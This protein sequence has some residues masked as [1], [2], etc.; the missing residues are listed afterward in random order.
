[1]SGD[2]GELPVY[3]LNST[4]I[5]Y[6]AVNVNILYEGNYTFE[7]VE[8]VGG[9]DEI[10]FSL[11][12]FLDGQWE[13]SSALYYIV[14]PQVLPNQDAID[15]YLASQNLTPVNLSAHFM[16]QVSAPDG[17]AN[18]QFGGSVS[19]SGDILA[20][21]ASWA[22]A[23]VGAA[24]LYRAE[25]NGTATYLS[26]VTAPD[27]AAN[28]YLGSSVSQS[29][30]LLAIGAF[31]SDPG[32]FSDAG[33]VYLY[34]VEQNGSAT[35]L[36]KVIA[37]DS[38]PGDYFG[39]SVS[40]SGDILAVGAHTSDPGGISDSGSAYLYRVEQNGTATFLDKV[41]AP[42]RGASDSFG[43]S[44]SLSGNLLAV[45][46]HK[47]DPGGVS[48]AGAA[49]LYRLEQNGS[50]TYLTKVTAPDA[51]SEDQFGISV[52]QSGDLLAV[53]AQYADSG[54]DS[55]VLADKG[56]V[57]MYRLEENGTATFL[58]KNNH[59]GGAA[60]DR[61]G[62]SVSLSGNLLVVGAKNADHGS[63][64]NAGAA[65]LYRIE[66]N[67]SFTYLERI[68]A[69]NGEGSDNFGYS[70]SHSGDFL[71][72][73]AIGADSTVADSAGVAYLFDVSDYSFG[74]GNF[75]DSGDGSYQGDDGGYQSDDGGYQSDDGG[76]QSDD[77]G[78]QSDDGGYQSDDGGYQSDDGGYQSD[79]GGYQSDDGGYQSDDG[80]YQSDDGGYQ[81]DD[82]GYQSDDGG[83][84]SD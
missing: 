22:S 16:A 46:S 62:G 30:D 21:G 25:Q 18:M 65:Y 35:Y 66:D 27:A 23:G 60:S 13:V 76:Y 39:K 26:K 52:S 53:G 44:L 43:A 83:Y 67:G 54:G 3:E 58:W 64:A 33:A 7:H 78:Y 32:G 42:D 73:S 9:Q 11:T 45:G 1:M 55:G 17:T 15:S 8:V 29:G 40:Q 77:G 37:P 68:V 75:T 71:A 20:V 63:V 5:N 57:Y 41:Y 31:G 51:T 72:V 80:G 19:Q 49:Y 47:S 84:Q 61:F 14:D 48:A 70:I 36:S 12:A 10:R 79:D 59:G 2:G 4:H 56:A 6:M 82:G 81:S 50:A 24:Y 74:D 69:P 34:R 38:G 28:D